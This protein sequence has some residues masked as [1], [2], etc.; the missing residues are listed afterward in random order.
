[1]TLSFVNRFTA[2]ATVA[3][4]M[5]STATSAT[6]TW[7]NGGDGVSTFQEANWVVTDDTGSAALAGLVGS[8]PPAGFLTASV[9]I[10]ADFI[11]GGAATAGG[12][13]GSPN[14]DLGEGFSGLVQ[15]DATLHARIGFSPFGGIRG[16]A[17]GAPETLTIQDNATLIARFLLD[18]QASF[19]G[20]STITLGGGGVG[21]V[22]N[23]TVELASDWTG[24]ITWPNFA[25][26]SGST[27]IDN[28]TVGGAPAVEGVNVFVTSDGTQSVLTLVPEPSSFALLAFCAIA[29]SRRTRDH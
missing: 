8:D 16:V 23:S 20:S 2:A 26:V 1:M 18:I 28:I 17:G 12:A 13:N 7:D 22:N 27:I 21:T 14:V 5:A 4:A 29:A 15:D 3:C 10:E 11:I 6:I 19:S 9:D 24:S 25:G